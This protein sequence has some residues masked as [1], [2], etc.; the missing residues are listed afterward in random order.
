MA[1]KVKHAS[2]DNFDFQQHY[3]DI[4]NCVPDIVYWVDVD[5]HLKGCNKNFVKALGLKSLRDFS[6]TPYDQMKKFTKWPEDRINAFK[7]DDMNVLFSGK[8][9]YH[10]EEKPVQ[11]SEVKAIHYRATRVPLFDK[12]KH[13]VGLVVVLT[14]LSEPQSLPAAP[15]LSIKQEKSLKDNLHILMVEDNFIAQ[16]VEEALF[17]SL[18]C[19]VDVAE[20]GDKALLLFN[21]GKYDIV[22]MGIGLQDASGYW[23]AKKIR[24][25]EKNTS[26]HVPI[27][28][29][30]SYQADVVKYDCND[31]AMD[32]V[33][34]KPLTPEQAQ[35]IIQHYIYHENIPVNGL[36]SVNEN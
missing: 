31:Y 25:K 13:V 20:T 29:L 34:T 18:H 4:I 21:P 10:I 33:L 22:F 6:G 35:Q 27:I 5:C 11:I 26:Y 36:R 7:L 24:Q 30:T 8:A 23:V 14:E 28:A 3:I 2:P 16:K 12:N 32:G 17:K 19:D 9:Q 1:K 15:K